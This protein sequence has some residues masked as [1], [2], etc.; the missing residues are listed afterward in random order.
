M[1]SKELRRLANKISKKKEFFKVDVYTIDKYDLDSGREVFDQVWM[2][3]T[4]D[5]LIANA[6]TED[7]E[8]KRVWGDKAG[9]VLG[10]IKP[11][12]FK[13][14]TDAFDYCEKN[15]YVWVGEPFPESWRNQPLIGKQRT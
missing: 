6:R 7:L 5:N 12:R 13:D 4:K 2:S 14:K 15:R 1:L 3:S 10:D 8:E 9:V 11:I